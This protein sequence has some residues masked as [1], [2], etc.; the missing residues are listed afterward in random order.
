MATAFGRQ[1]LEEKCSSVFVPPLSTPSNI[2]L[3]QMSV[4]RRV[5]VFLSHAIVMPMTL[6]CHNP[7]K[8]HGPKG[9]HK[10]I[11]E[12]REISVNP[13]FI[14]YFLIYKKNPG[15]AWLPEKWLGLHSVIL[16]EDQ[17]Q[18]CLC[19]VLCDTSM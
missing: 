11:T 9:N 10:E 4:E 3:A 2:L 16:G 19:Y 7:T 18:G 5:S 8:Q 15:D 17:P 14:F 12:R 13:G 6:E 1:F